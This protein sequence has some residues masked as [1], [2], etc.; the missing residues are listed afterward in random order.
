MRP[1]LYSEIAKERCNA[2]AFG[3]FNAVVIAGGTYKENK[4]DKYTTSQLEEFN[5]SLEYV[6]QD[7]YNK[8]SK[9]T[10]SFKIEKWLSRDEWNVFGRIGSEI[11]SRSGYS[12]SE[13]ANRRN[14][15]RA[16]RLNNK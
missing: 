11:S 4:F 16:E 12:A 5:S 7:R 10:E 13:A 8:N 9:K 15:R 2:K 1:V 3:A 6:A 14:A